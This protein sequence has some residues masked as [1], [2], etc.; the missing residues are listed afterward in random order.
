M[1]GPDILLS[2][3]PSHSYLSFMESLPHFWHQWTVQTLGY[4]DILTIDKH[5]CL[6][7]PCL[8]G[9]MAQCRRNVG[10]VSIVVAAMQCVVLE[11][12]H[13]V[14]RLLAPFSVWI[15][16]LV[17]RGRENMILT[18]LFKL[19]WCLTPGCCHHWSAK[20]ASLEDC[21]CVCSF[22]SDWQVMHAGGAPPFL[23]LD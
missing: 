2:C 11:L 12:G 20:S 10:Q 3:S 13:G 6:R 21:P 14:S 7:V 17:G 22:L 4:Q 18:N 23:K 8:V 9:G 5:T 1:Q 19:L 15:P 16:S